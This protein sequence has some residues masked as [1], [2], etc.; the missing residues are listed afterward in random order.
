MAYTNDTLL[1]NESTVINRSGDAEADGEEPGSGWGTWKVA[2]ESGGELE[3]C[4]G[5][6]GMGGGSPWAYRRH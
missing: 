1:C 6:L 3:G 5:V 2:A 4:H